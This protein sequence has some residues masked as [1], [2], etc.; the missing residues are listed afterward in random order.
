M[1]RSSLR[2]VVAGI[3]L[4]CVASCGWL[5]Y[6]LSGVYRTTTSD[7]LRLLARSCTE[8][9]YNLQYCLGLVPTVPPIYPSLYQS[10][11]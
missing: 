9:A 2:L 10:T 7:D 6:S 1:R 5:T 8:S 3:L 4:V 11:R